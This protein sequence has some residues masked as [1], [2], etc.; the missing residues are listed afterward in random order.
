M[1]LTSVEEVDGYQLG[2]TALTQVSPNRLELGA[3]WQGLAHFHGRVGRRVRS[4][5]DQFAVLQPYDHLPLH[6]TTLFQPLGSVLP[7]DVPFLGDEL[8]NRVEKLSHRHPLYGPAVARVA[9]G[10]SSR[11]CGADPPGGRCLPWSGTA[12]LLGAA[13]EFLLQRFDLRYG[14]LA[15]VEL[16]QRVKEVLVDPRL[17]GTAQPGHRLLQAAIEVA[18]VRQDDGRAATDSSRAVDHHLAL[19]APGV[20]ELAEG[21]DLGRERRVRVLHP[22]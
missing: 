22:E 5:G 10:G 21:R 17:D 20:D 18:Q 2:D 15:T 11:L 12:I 1:A 9:S 13:Q 8:P 4:L 3:V 14:Q 6:D 19:A 7:D 16:G